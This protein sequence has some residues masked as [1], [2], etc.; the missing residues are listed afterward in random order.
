[1]TRSVSSDQEQC[2]VSLRL[3]AGTTRKDAGH[4]WPPTGFEMARDTP[5]DLNP[6]NRR[7]IS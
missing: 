7:D 1:M 4:S 3:L 5:P 2:T 6:P